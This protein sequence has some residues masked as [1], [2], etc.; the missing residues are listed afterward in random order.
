[1]AEG[2]IK[3]LVTD[4][5]FGFITQADGSEIFFH[6][7]KV[8]GDFESLSEGQRVSYETAMDPRRNKENAEQVTPL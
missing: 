2:T 1:M 3:R 5:G 8:T 7:S 4:R 6:R